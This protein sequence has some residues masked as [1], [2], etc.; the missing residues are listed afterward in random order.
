MK[1]RWPRTSSPQRV[2]EKRVARRNA[3]L[4]IA[5]PPSQTGIMASPGQSKHIHGY[6][7]TPR[8]YFTLKT[9]CHDRTKE[10]YARGKLVEHFFSILSAVRA[11]MAAARGFETRE[12]LGS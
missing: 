3:L 4:Q 8:V 1:S 5:L 12:Q 6:P 10:I 11:T 9:A 2:F 7:Q